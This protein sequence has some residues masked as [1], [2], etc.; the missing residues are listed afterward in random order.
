[1]T[2][3]VILLEKTREKAAGDFASPGADIV[4]I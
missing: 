4:S 2:Y 3:I 1:M